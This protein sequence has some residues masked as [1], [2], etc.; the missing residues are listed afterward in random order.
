MM[1][2]CLE[3]VGRHLHYVGRLFGG[4]GEAVWSVW[5]GWLEG[6]AS[7]SGGC[8]DAVLRVWGRLSGGVEAV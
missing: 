4:C 1:G 5:G 7:M 8:G 2:G 3:G 6:K